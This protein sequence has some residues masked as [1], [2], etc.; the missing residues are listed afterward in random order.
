M[1][2]LKV[3]RPAPKGARRP[4]GI[5][6]SE[7]AAANWRLAWQGAPLKGFDLGPPLGKPGAA[8]RRPEQQFHR[9]RACAWQSM[10]RV[11][12]G[13]LWRSGG[14]CQELCGL[15][16]PMVR[17]S[18]PPPDHNVRGSHR[19]TPPLS[20]FGHARKGTEDELAWPA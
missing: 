11:T 10:V 4:S 6:R 19:P 7:I 9:P 16:W 14:W 5:R 3:R 15:G 12:R 2:I 1:S 17:I 8:I 13:Y 20:C 18:K